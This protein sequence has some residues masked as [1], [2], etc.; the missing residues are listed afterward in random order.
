MVSQIID[1][2][3][4]MMEAVSTELS[5]F[6]KAS[7]TDFETIPAIGF[8]SCSIEELDVISDGMK[9]TISIPVTIAD[10][11]ADP[12]VNL[13][14]AQMYND[15]RDLFYTQIGPDFLTD[16]L[17]ETVIFGSRFQPKPYDGQDQSIKC[18]SGEVQF[19]ID[20]TPS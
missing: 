4:G 15:F 5:I 7:D 9:A 1:L 14:L 6:T 18:L 13:S 19:I 16:G 20:L 17:A 3:M 2:Y 10:A 12:D 11:G 8:G